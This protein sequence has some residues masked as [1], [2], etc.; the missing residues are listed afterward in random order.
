MGPYYGLIISVGFLRL[1]TIGAIKNRKNRDD[2]FVVAVCI[3][4]ILL[5]SFRK[6]TVGIDLGMYIPGYELSG[7]LPWF[8]PVFNFEIGYRV[9]CKV[10]YMIGVSQQLFLGIV[11]TICQSSVFMFIRKHSK[12]PAISIVIYLTFGLFTFSFSGLRQMIAFSIA[13]FSYD[14]VEK[15]EWIPFCVI[16]GVASLFHTSVLVFL[17]VYPLYYWKFPKNTVIFM[18]PVFIFEILFGNKVV[19]LM[20]TIYKQT[21]YQAENTGAYE[22]FLMYSLVWIAAELFMKYTNEYNAYR[23]YLLIGALVQGLGLYH[24][25]VARVGYY[26]MFFICLVLPQTIA[27]ICKDDWKLRFCI[28]SALVVCCFIFFNINT[29]SGYLNVS[30]YIPFWED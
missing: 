11:A 15:K 30:P 8:S 18:F 5:Q 6:N 29:G 14:F 3:L 7:Q 19:A 4:T 9:F 28:T 20:V 22:A 27:D 1:M 16:I 23:N 24:S 2:I 12:F 10:L 13:L 17:I 26:F 21:D 25:S